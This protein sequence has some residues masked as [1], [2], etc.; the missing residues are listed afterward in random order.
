MLPLSGACTPKITIE[1]MQRP[2]ISDICAS[3]S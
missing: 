3:F 1:Y 2:M